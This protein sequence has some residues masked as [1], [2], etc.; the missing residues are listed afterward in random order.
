MLLTAL[1]TAG[2]LYVA[3]LLCSTLMFELYSP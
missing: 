3:M 2:L 1:E